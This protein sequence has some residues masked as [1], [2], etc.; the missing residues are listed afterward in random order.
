MIL[1]STRTSRERERERRERW[2]ERERE[3]ER[4]REKATAVCVVCVCVCVCVHLDTRT[5]PLD[6]IRTQGMTVAAE[7]VAKARW[8][9]SR[10]RRARIYTPA[11]ALQQS[12]LSSFV[13]AGSLSLGSAL[14]NETRTPTSPETL[15]R[16]SSVQERLLAAAG[17]LTPI[18]RMFLCGVRAC[19]RACRL[20]ATPRVWLAQCGQRC[21]SRRLHAAVRVAP[22]RLPA[23]SGG[24]ERSGWCR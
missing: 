24:R 18:L 4:E 17:G 21:A 1:S 7:C 8:H 15:W 11:K 13:V 5:L 10:A 9:T 22:P 6:G 19:D 23:A 2:K 14:L 3:R 20:A 16:R 12:I